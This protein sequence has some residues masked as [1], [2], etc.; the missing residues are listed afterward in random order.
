MSMINLIALTLTEIIG[1]FGYEKF[2][3]TGKI[4]GFVQGSIGYIG[5]IF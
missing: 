5:V 2:A 1:D 3:D 4:S